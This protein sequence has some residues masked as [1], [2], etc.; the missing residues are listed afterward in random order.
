MKTS[1]RFAKPFAR[2]PALAI[3]WIVLLS[4][5]SGGCAKHVSYVNADRALT[6]LKTGEPAPHDG[7][8]MSEGYL[9]DIYEAL[10]APRA[11]QSNPLPLPES[12]K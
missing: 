5:W 3:A 12:S 4:C 7:V 1:N 6:R 8:L 9:S 2:R 11:N 10:K